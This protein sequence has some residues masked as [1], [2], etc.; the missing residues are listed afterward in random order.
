MAKR[1]ERTA[2]T[3]SLISTAT[4]PRVLSG[5]DFPNSKN[6]LKEYA[7]HN[8]RKEEIEYADAVLDILDHL[9]SKRYS[10]MTDVEREVEK[11]K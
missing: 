5:I 2:G 9:P 1:R 3:S 6:D 11:I 7:V 4:I 8:L 10:N